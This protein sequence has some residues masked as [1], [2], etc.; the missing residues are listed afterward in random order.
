M[1]DRVQRF[2]ISFLGCSFVFLDL[3][4]GACEK[5]KEIRLTYEAASGQKVNMSESV[6][7][8]NPRASDV[9]KTEAKRVLGN[10]TI[11]CHEKYLGLSSNFGRNRRR[12]FNYIKERVWRK[13][14]L[15]KEM[16]L[17]KAGKEVLLRLWFKPSLPIL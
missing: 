16:F 10:P 7:C 4:V 5:M 2:P 1:L 11:N 6:M 12:I 8:F 13:L 17:S 14:K 3:K 15:W 9:V